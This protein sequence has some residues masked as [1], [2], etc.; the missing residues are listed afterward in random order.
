[1][2]LGWMLGAYWVGDG[3]VE[4]LHKTILAKRREEAEILNEDSKWPERTAAG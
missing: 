1:M 4:M 3:L 2:A